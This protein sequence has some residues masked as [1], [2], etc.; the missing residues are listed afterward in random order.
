MQELVSAQALPPYSPAV[1]PQGCVVD[2]RKGVCDS[3]PVKL[4]HQLIESCAQAEFRAKDS[5]GVHI[6]L[7]GNRLKVLK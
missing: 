1:D 2:H 3:P 4:A 6:L 5:R 7:S